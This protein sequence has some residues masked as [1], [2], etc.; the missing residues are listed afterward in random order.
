MLSDEIALKLSHIFTYF[1]KLKGIVSPINIFY[2][3]VFAQI[4]NC[5]G[6]NEP[7]KY[8]CK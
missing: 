4:F 5:C 8:S 7:V 2:D 3:E 1:Q 6:N